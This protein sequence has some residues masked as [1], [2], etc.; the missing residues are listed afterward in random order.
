ME[1]VSREHFMRTHDGKNVSLIGARIAPSSVLTKLIDKL[2]DTDFYQIALTTPVDSKYTG[3]FHRMSH[4]FYR[5][6]TNGERSYKDF[7]K[8]SYII[9]DDRI[10]IIVSPSYDDNVIVNEYRIEK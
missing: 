2:N 10:S 6:M 7:S 8:G 9:S 4:G 5:E 1:K 3:V